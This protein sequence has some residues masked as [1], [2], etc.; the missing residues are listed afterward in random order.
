[1]NFRKLSRYGVIGGFIVIFLAMDHFI[2]TY[3]EGS[4]KWIYLVLSCGMAIVLFNTLFA[5]RP[6]R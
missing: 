6:K 2:R 1:M 3:K 5:R 4:P